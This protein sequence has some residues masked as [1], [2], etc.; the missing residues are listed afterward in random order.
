MKVGRKRS[1]R[2]KRALILALVVLSAGGITA[3][4]RHIIQMN[5]KCTALEDDRITW[6]AAAHFV[7]SHSQ[8]SL[9]VR[10][11]DGKYTSY[12]IIGYSGPQEYLDRYPDCCR[13]Y[14]DRLD[15]RGLTFGERYLEG[16][17]GFVEITA[18]HHYM[19][20]GRRITDFP[21]SGTVWIIDNQYRFIDAYPGR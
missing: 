8:G 17:C 13:Y 2:L 11:P 6:E 18:H 15:G 5:A 3:L 12:P 7:K 21:A 10:G 14:P 9:G 16:K 1:S 20:D 19:K 4:S